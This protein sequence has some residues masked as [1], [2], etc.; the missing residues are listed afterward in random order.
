MWKLLPR[1]LAALAAAATLAALV[2]P[3]SP[4]ATLTH[5]LDRGASL[6]AFW[7]PERLASAQSLDAPR[8]LFDPA[9]LRTARKPVPGFTSSPVGSPGSVPFR[10]AGK[11]FL[12]LGGKVY[13]CSAAIVKSDRGNLIWTAGHC[14]RDPGLGGKFASKLVFIPA[15]DDGSKPFG[16]WRADAAAVPRGWGLGNQHYDFGAATL[17]RRNGRSVANKVGAALP[18]DAKPKAKQRWTAVGY[19]QAGRFGDR[20]WSCESPFYRRD[21]FRGSGPDP[22]GIG[23]DMTG[24]ASGGPWLT[25]K[26]KLGAVSSYLI[27]RRP[28][29]LFG[30]YMGGEAGRLYE[31]LRDRG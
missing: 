26:G 16:I 9:A 4:A 29:A 18:F 28:D 23:C 3:A 20:M 31:R 25:A 17:A 24:G 13:A 7:T 8:S 6:R 14:L 30:T 15:Y 10:A 22:L 1:A 19:P 12:R 11:V 5:R 21:R 27:R 2:A